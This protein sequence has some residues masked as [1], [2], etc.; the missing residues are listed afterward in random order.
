M[1]PILFTSFLLSLF[2]INRSDRAR[3]AGRPR[4]LWASLSPRIWLDPEPYQ[5]PNDSTW[6]TATTSSSAAH[7]TPSSALN[8][9]GLATGADVASA[10]GLKGRKGAQKWHLNN[11]IRKISKIE[12]TDAF[13]WQGFAA[14]ALIFGILFVGIGLIVGLGYMTMV[15]SERRFGIVNHDR[16][17]RFF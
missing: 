2:L 12:I 5:D 9:K 4:G 16:G 7:Y 14:V 8:P 6:N 3:R 17:G 1:T 13:E 15:Y 11:S 10:A